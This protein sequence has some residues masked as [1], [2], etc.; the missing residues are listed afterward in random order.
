[1]PRQGLVHGK[2]S[3]C[4]LPEVTQIVPGKP[5]AESLP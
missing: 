5:E 4:D 1:M 3:L 2:Q